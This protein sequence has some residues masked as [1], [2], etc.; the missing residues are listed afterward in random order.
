[1]R[2]LAD[3]RTSRTQISSSCFELRWTLLFPIV[4]SYGFDRPLER[5][6][7][8]RSDEKCNSLFRCRMPELLTEIDHSSRQLGVDVQQDPVVDS[9]LP[10][11]AALCRRS[12]RVYLKPMSPEYAYQQ[13]LPEFGSADEKDF[14]SPAKFMRKCGYALQTGLSSKR[15]FLLRHPPD[16]RRKHSPQ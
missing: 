16:P 5:N 15:D 4:F 14:L 9:W 7:S 8:G 6:V 3:V 10:K 13:A 11:T 12:G 2:S 1:M